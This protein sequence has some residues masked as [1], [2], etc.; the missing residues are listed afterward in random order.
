[1]VTGKV[2][3]REFEIPEFDCETKELEEYRYLEKLEEELS[4]VAEDEAE[5]ETTSDL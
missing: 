3:V 5:Y 2:D 4:M 1:M